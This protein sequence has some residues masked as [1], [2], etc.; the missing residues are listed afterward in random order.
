MLREDLGPR[1]EAHSRRWEL[2]DCAARADK[3]G[4]RL[5]TDPY[6]VQRALARTKHGALYLLDKWTLIGETVEKTG[7]IDDSLIQSCYDILGIEHIYRGGCSRIPAGTDID[8]LRAL[9]ARETGRLRLSLER[10]LNARSESEKDMCQLGITRHLQP[11]T[12]S[13]RGDLNRARR[14]F[15]WAMETLR[16]LQNGADAASLI[17]PDTGKPI[18]AGPPP[19]A[20]PEPNRPAAPPSPSA[21]PQPAPAAPPSPS[22][23]PLP[24]GCS[25][26][27]K[28]MLLVAAGAILNKSAMPP[29]DEPGPPPTA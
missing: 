7:G 6:H 23:P 16:M 20:V 11:E 25:E 12:K 28:D 4:S 24:A 18:A 21:S 14:R 13:L 26:E 9:V 1:V 3:L 19:S 29:C 17:D 15:T 22:I 27:L 10:T 5:A 2:D 8:A